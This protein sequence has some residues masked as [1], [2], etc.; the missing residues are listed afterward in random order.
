M[1]KKKYLVAC[2]FIGIFASSNIKAEGKVHLTFE[3]ALKLAYEQSTDYRNAKR[4]LEKAQL[5]WQLVQ[6]LSQTYIQF[7]G[8]YVY[9][10]D[11]VKQT[12]LE[13]PFDFSITA[14]IPILPLLT[15]NTS[16]ASSGVLTFGALYVPFK[17]TQNILQAQIQLEKA[18][19]TLKMIQFSVLRSCITYYAAV[20]NAYWSY[21]YAQTQE[22]SAK[23]AV[24]IADIEYKK[25]SLAYYDYSS[26]Q[27]NY[28]AAEQSLLKAITD[29]TNALYNLSVF[30]HVDVESIA[31][32]DE[33]HL[34]DEIAFITEEHLKTAISFEKY[35][36]MQK[37]Y[38]EIVLDYQAKQA[39]TKP[40]FP[41]T[42]IQSTVSYNTITNNTS[43][44]L[45]GSIK[46]GSGTITQNSYAI[47]KLELEQMADTLSDL[48]NKY[49]TSYT[50]LVRQI[51][52]YKTAYTTAY[53]Q[54]EKA[55]KNYAFIQT[56]FSKESAGQRELLQAQLG[57]VNARIQLEQYWW[58]LQERLAEIG[59]LSAK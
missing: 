53:V 5:E 9:S 37:D 23:I 13:K 42:T 28:F 55:I 15:V 20:H 16:Y 10:S 35:L 32:A 34:P 44:V 59:F 58:Q 54:Y 51:L 18:N 48:Y 57:F 19:N 21:V 11:Y 7:N 6:P 36:S 41:E 30:L 1:N 50:M 46:L 45:S 39:E 43:V 29:Y 2:I 33:P 47:Q 25:G 12:S 24:D 8:Q 26:I 27:A 49:K 52:Q 3:D 31:V 56:L 4:A 14:G 22:Q 17:T 38:A 40:V